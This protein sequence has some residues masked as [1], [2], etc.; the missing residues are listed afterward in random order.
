MMMQTTPLL[1]I[2]MGGI[3]AI[4]NCKVGG[5]KAISNCSNVEA[6]ILPQARLCNTFSVQG[7]KFCELLTDYFILY[8]ATTHKSTWDLLKTP[9]TYAA[10]MMA[11]CEIKLSEVRSNAEGLNFYKADCSKF[12]SLEAILRVSSLSLET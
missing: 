2:M 1:A 11:T 7:A 3:Q 10:T 12:V 5:T 8:R 6:G 9:M 4:Y